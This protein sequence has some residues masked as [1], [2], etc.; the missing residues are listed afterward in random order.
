MTTNIPWLISVAEWAVFVLYWSAA[1]KNASPAASSESRNSRRIHEVLVNVAL[2]LVIFPVRP[3][4]NIAAWA[5]LAI[6]TASGLL[7]VWAR[8]HL[9]AHWSGEITIKVDHKLIQSGPYRFIR[10][11]IYTAMLGMFVGTTL[12][13]GQLHA[14]LGLAMVVFAYWRKIRLEEANLRQAFGP[15]YDAYRRDTWVLIPGLL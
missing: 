15:A 8:R 3:G 6:Q 14:L 10:H 7:G 9:G 13:S 1:A 11:P 4:T 5:G 12:L 2:L